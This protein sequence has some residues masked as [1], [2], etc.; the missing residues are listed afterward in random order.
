MISRKNKKLVATLTLASAIFVYISISAIDSLLGIPKWILSY[1]TGA[2]LFA[3]APG[4]KKYKS[5]VEKKKKKH[6]AIVLLAKS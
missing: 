4:I 6:D 1:A 2:E 5:I 3:I